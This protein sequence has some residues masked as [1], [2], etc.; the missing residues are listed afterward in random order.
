[1]KKI[2]YVFALSLLVSGLRAADAVPVQTGQVKNPD[3][4]AQIM[5]FLEQNG[6]TCHNQ[7]QAFLA[8]N[9]ASDS[10]YTAIHQSFADFLNCSEALEQAR[11]ILALAN[12]TA[13]VTTPVGLEQVGDFTC[14]IADA[15]VPVVLAGAQPVETADAAET[16]LD[17]TDQNA[18]PVA[19][20]ISTDLEVAAAA[21]GV[22]GANAS[23]SLLQ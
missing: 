23:D 18:I 17:V 13:T 14:I 22:V 4:V 11:N 6:I 1:M 12:N 7:A 2:K 10:T 20:V 9:T 3:L 21:A 19:P 16:P 5:V 15:A 8:L